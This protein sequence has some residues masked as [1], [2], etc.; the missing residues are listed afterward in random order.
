MLLFLTRVTLLVSFLLM[1]GW[2]ATE[3]IE[4]SAKVKF[5]IEPNK[6]IALIIPHTE[7]GS[8]PRSGWTEC[9]VTGK[10]AADVRSRYPGKKEAEAFFRVQYRKLEKDKQ[11][12]ILRY[13]G[14]LLRL[15][16]WSANFQKS[17]D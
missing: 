8:Y 1:N 2:A 14:E 11:S 17:S 4:E 6:V 9:V 3:L 16:P 15:Q 10:L 12:P 5:S 13:R 7:N